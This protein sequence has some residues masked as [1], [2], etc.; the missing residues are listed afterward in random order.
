MMG[1]LDATTH[2]LIV[3]TSSTKWSTDFI[4]LLEQ[5]DG[6]FGPKPGRQ[7]KPGVLVLDHGPIHTSKASTAA[8]A[9]RSWITV[10]RLPRYAP[11]LNDIERS[12]RDPKRL[13]LAHRTFR[14]A[15]ELD[16]AIHAV[17]TELY[18]ERQ[19]AHPGERSRIAAQSP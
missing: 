14:D 17:M 10:E 15:A 11:E 2:E 3:H 1:A 19:W 4:A 8:L 5:L 13:H 9:A 18:H 12:W 7:T 6:R 16:A